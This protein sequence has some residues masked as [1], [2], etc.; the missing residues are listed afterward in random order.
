[1]D[2][3]EFDSTEIDVSSGYSYRTHVWRTADKLI[4]TAFTLFNDPEQAAME[5]SKL[6]MVWKVAELYPD[7]QTGRWLS[8]HCD[9]WEDYLKAAKNRK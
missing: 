7:T 5:Y 4:D 3:E 6:A 1:V 8:Q 2:E 9:R